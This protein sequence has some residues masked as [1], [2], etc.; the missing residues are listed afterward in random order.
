MINQANGIVDI[1]LD[2]LLRRLRVDPIGIKDPDYD[3]SDLYL[4][5]MTVEVA[6]TSNWRKY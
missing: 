3:D 1:E 2:Q 5:R 4:S 6:D